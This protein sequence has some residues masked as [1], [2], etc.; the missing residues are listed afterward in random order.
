MRCSGPPGAASGPDASGNHGMKPMPCASQAS[1]TGSA[2]R[3]VRLYMFCTDTIG[4]DLLGGLEL[5]DVDLGQPDVA[6]LAL[7]LQRHQFADL[8]F[9]RELGVDAVQL[10]QVDGVDAEAAQ[11]HLALLAQ[12]AGK[13]SRRPLVGTGAQQT[14]LRRDRRRRRR[15]AAPRG[16]APRTRTGRRSRRCR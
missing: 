8:V 7:L 6:D 3:A 10:E 11:A 4:R 9:G 13:P 5:L 2:A 14:G 12:V 15:G 16:S 1:S